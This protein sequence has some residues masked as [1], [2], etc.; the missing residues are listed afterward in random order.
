MRAE[1]RKYRLKEETRRLNLEYAKTV[2]LG[3]EGKLPLYDI[4]S[5]DKQEET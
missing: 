5:F 3:A 4:N 2:L 1:V